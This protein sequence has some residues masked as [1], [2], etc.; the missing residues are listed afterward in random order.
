MPTSLYAGLFCFALDSLLFLWS[1]G[2]LGLT[3][4]A[5]FEPRATR[6]TLS[7]HLTRIRRR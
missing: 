4:R 2:A 3:L 5:L 7:D 1:C 6:K